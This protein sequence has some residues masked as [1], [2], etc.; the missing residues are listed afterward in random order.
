MRITFFHFFYINTTKKF[1]SISGLNFKK[2]NNFAL[3]IG[4]YKKVKKLITP[5]TRVRNWTEKIEIFSN[6]SGKEFREKLDF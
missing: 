3:V 6:Y 2:I 5:K 4:R 1:I